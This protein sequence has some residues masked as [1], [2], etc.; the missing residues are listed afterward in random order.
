LSRIGE[1]SLKKTS[2]FTIKDVE[3]DAMVVGMRREEG[4]K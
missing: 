3:N 4:V 2:G 1:P